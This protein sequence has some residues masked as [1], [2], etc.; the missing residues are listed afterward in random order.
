MVWL[1][2]PGRLAWKLSSSAAD[3]TTATFCFH[4]YSIASCASGGLLMAPSAS[5]MIVAPESTAKI[6]ATPKS[7][8]STT[9][10]SPARTMI[11]V[12]SGQTPA[13]EMPLLV[14]ATESLASPVPW[15][16]SVSS[17]GSLSSRKA[18]QP[19]MSSVQPLPSS[20]TVSDQSMIRSSGS[21]RPLP[22]ASDSPGSQIVSGVGSAWPVA[23]V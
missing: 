12:H 11:T 17:A 6:A 9:N 3:A 13:S 1:T 14:S 18:S 7:L 23:V 10:E 19:L 8:A 22:L 4:A 21:S 15:P 16:K 20:S 5:W 2:E